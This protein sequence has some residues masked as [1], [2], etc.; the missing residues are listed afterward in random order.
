MLSRYEDINMYIYIYDIYN[1]NISLG[2]VYHPSQFP[3]GLSGN[4]E[5]SESDPEPA[6]DVVG[7]RTRV[8]Q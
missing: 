1:I 3:G 7:Q 5:S 8:V 2:P 6:A 4:F